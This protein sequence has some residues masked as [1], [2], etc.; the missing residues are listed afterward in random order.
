MMPTET[1]IR[2]QIRS[3]LRGNLG[4]PISSSDRYRYRKYVSKRRPR[5]G[6]VR[7]KDVAKRHSSGGNLKM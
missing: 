7:R 3:S 5:S 1:Q 2:Y 6:L 4:F